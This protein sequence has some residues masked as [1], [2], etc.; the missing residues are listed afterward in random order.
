MFGDRGFNQRGG[1]GSNRDISN[2]FGVKIRLER[3]TLKGGLPMAVTRGA[4]CEPHPPPRLRPTQ[5]G[6]PGLIWGVPACS[7]LNLYEVGVHCCLSVSSPILSSS[8][9]E[10]PY[11]Y[12][13]Y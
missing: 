8:L 9:S 10:A 13:Y 12:Y 5:T 6:G 3:Q 2:C 4:V 11:Y 1:A 7:R